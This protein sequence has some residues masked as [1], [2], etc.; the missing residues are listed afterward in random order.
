MT[1]QSTHQS[2]HYSGL[3]STLA[4]PERHFRLFTQV[5]RYSGILGLSSSTPTPA[6]QFQVAP[7]LPSFQSGHPASADGQKDSLLLESF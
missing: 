1:S 6:Q 3:T 4:N 5:H 7:T 2:G